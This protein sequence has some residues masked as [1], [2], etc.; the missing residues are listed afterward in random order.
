MEITK[1]MKNFIQIIFLRNEDKFKKVKE[2]FPLLEA[3]FKEK[4]IIL[5]N[6][7]V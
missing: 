6:S 7:K 1:V 3:Y 4:I 5:N 2:W